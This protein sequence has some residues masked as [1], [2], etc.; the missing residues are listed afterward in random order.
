MIERVSGQSTSGDARRSAV[1]LEPRHVAVRA[2]GEKT[3][4]SRFQFRR[5]IRFHNAKGVESE[6]ARSLRKRGFYR[7][8]VF[9]K[10]RSA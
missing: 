6:R 7:E 2:I 10:S 5:R 3:F 1:E 8:R 9:Q 4:E